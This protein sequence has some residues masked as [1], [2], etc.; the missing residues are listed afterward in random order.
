MEEDGGSVCRLRRSWKHWCYVSVPKASHGEAIVH[1]LVRCKHALRLFNNLLLTLSMNCA[2]N[3]GSTCCSVGAQP[4]TTHQSSG[5]LRALQRRVHPRREDPSRRRPPTGSRRRTFTSPPPEH[6]SEVTTSL[7]HPSPCIQHGHTCFAPLRVT[8]RV[9]YTTCR[10]RQCNVRTT[11][12]GHR[13]KSPASLGQ[14][15]VCR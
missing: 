15:L 13:L 4:T 11:R 6:H 9:G 8:S 1:T 2:G 10:V 14:P 12:R 3:M 5:H 7:S